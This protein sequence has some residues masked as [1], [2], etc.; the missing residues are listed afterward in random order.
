MGI[1][2]VED[3]IGYEI[4][5]LIEFDHQRLLT[6]NNF[7]ST[8]DAEKIANLCIDLRDISEKA[9]EMLE[10]ILD[11]LEKLIAYTSFINLQER[12]AV[13]FLYQMVFQTLKRSHKIRKEQAAIISYFVKNL[14]KIKSWRFRRKVNKLNQLV[15]EERKLMNDIVIFCQHHAP[16]IEKA[17]KLLK[18]EKNQDRIA[19]AVAV[20]AWLAPGIGIILSI[21]IL[22]IYN[23]SKKF[24][25]L[26]KSLEQLR[27]GS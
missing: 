2:K 19:R 16:N 25:E 22:K 27:N 11:D 23:F 3:Q 9:F 24:T 8:T 6:I 1:N 13:V 4:A 5:H 12:R 15:A 14:H 18:S 7:L 21:V 17:A 10:R 26:H 20:F